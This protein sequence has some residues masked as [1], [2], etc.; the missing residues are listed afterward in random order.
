VTGSEGMLEAMVARLEGRVGELQGQ[1]MELRELVDR[2]L[3]ERERVL[4]GWKEI[5][6]YLQRSVRQAQRLADVRRCMDPLPIRRDGGYVVAYAMQIDAW[7]ARMA[8]AR[9]KGHSSIRS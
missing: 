6:A 3:T 4:V 1:V 9:S 8:T 5:A 2:K 7:K